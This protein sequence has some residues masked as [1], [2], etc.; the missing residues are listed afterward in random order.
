MTQNNNECLSKLIWDRCPK[1]TFVSR[2]VIEDATY[3]AVSYFNDD[4]TSAM[5][6]L[7]EL[8]LT[9]GHFTVGGL[10]KA[11]DIPIHLNGKFL[12]YS[13]RVITFSNEQKS[14]NTLTRIH[15]LHH[16]VNKFIESLMWPFCPTLP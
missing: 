6:M 8:K 5:S 15:T 16:D 3:S 2:L 7:C 1:E 9:P 10:Y 4:N 11:N 14:Q 13:L 12:L